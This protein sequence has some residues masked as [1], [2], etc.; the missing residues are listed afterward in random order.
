M[1]P[2][3]IDFVEPYGWL[4]VWL[5][6]ALIAIGAG[7]GF[8]WRVLQLTGNTNAISLQADEIQAN[9]AALNQRAAH[10]KSPRGTSA[11]KAISLIQFDMNKVFAVAENVDVNGTRLRGFVLDGVSG[12]LSL[13]YALDQPTHAHD[14]TEALNA[15]Y[16]ARPW[17]LERVSGDSMAAGGGGLQGTPTKSTNAAQWRSETSRL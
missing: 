6:F 4:R 5:V 17:R 3:R 7:G 11:G 14:I 16:E 12:T 15:G 1:K 13:E 9:I 8:T 2:L 10:Q